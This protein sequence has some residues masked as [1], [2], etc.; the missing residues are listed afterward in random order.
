MI[1]LKF[2]MI[3]YA[4]AVECVIDFLKIIIDTNDDNHY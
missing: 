3:T 1:L 4:F 2:D